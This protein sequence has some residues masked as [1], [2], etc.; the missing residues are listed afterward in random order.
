M[1]EC[2]DFP[3]VSGDRVCCEAAQF[4]EVMRIDGDHIGMRL[5]RL[6][7]QLPD[8]LEKAAIGMSSVA[9]G[10]TLATT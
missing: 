5:R 8:R 7:G 6:G 10:L 2:A 3:G 9:I 4:L 1:K